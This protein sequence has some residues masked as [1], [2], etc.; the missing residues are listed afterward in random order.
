MDI[1]FSACGDWKND[2]V[3][4]V[5]SVLREFEAKIRGELLMVYHSSLQSLDFPAITICNLNMIRREKLETLQ[6]TILLRVIEGLEQRSGRR[7]T[8]L[9]QRV[10]ITSINAT[11]DVIRQK[12]QAIAKF[13]KEYL[14]S[15]AK[16]ADEKEILSNAEVDIKSLENN[17]LDKVLKSIP[18]D[19]LSKVGHDLDEMLKY[20]RWSSFNCKTG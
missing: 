19:E 20:C 1:V 4:N 7:P 2:N 13:K 12:I 11:E 3:L 10:N 14:L 16:N 15:K 5:L 8:S 18:E 17:F 9:E 6:K